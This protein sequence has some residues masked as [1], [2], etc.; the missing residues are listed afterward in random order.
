MLGGIATRRQLVAATSRAEVDRALTEGSIVA[1]AR[2]RYA[3]PSVDEARRAAH[4]V[5]GTLGVLSAALHHGW[6]VRLPP[7]TPQV[8]VPRGRKVSAAQRAGVEVVH[9]DL[10]PDDVVDGATSRERTLI[11]VAR[12]CADADVLAVFDSA[13]RDGFS[14]ARLVALVRDARGPHVR[15][16]RRLAAVADAR[17]ANPFESALRAIALEVPGLCVRPQVP[18]YGARFLGRPD[19]VDVDLRIVLEAESFEWHGDRV[20]L[21]ADA[22]RFNGLGVHGWLVLRFTWEDVMFRPDDVRLVLVAAVTERT[23]LHR[24]CGHAA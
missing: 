11:D 21:S 3:L 20:A 18:L 4:R 10:G 19:L 13:L 14:H 24:D 8:I 16:M 7:D 22:R 17:A 2:G 6:A 12:R 5:S 9:L 23:H 1:E 15:R